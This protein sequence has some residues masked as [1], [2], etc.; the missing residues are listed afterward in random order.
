M[1]SGAQRS[2][3]ISTS[4]LTPNASNEAIEMLRLR[5][6]PLSMTEKQFA[7]QLPYLTPYPFPG[8]AY[9]FCPR[10]PAGF[11]PTRRARAH[12]GAE[13]HGWGAAG[14]AARGSFQPR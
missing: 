10:K 6:A 7:K 13:Q 12:L 8:R 3:S 5:Y 11:Y 1:L 9:A 4:L 14:C 2:R